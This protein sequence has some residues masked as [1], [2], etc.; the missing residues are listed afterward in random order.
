MRAEQSSS[1][2]KLDWLGLQDAWDI[3]FL[4]RC[5]ILLPYV[6][7]IYPLPTQPLREPDD[8]LRRPSGGCSHRS[9]SS[10]VTL[11]KGP[12]LHGSDLIGSS[13]W[14]GAWNILKLPLLQSWLFRC[15]S[16]HSSHAQGPTYRLII[17]QTPNHPKSMT[18]PCVL[19]EA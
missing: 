18:N 16:H 7:I 19:P 17:G 14:N 5:H 11:G 9:E 3:P 8:A 12:P 1:D 15:H 6:A 2:L 10:G 13:W 4:D